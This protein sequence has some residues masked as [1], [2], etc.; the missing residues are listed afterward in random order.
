MWSYGI[1]YDQILTTIKSRIYSV[2]PPYLGTTMASPI[3]FKRKLQSSFSKILGESSF[4]TKLVE[5]LYS[6]Y[7]K[8]LSCSHMDFDIAEVGGVPNEY[9]ERHD[10]AFLANPFSEE[11]LEAARRVEH[12]ENIFKHIEKAIIK[13]TILSLN[14]GCIGQ[15]L[16]N[17]LIFDGH[18][19]GLVGYQSQLEIKKHMQDLA[20]TD[21]VSTH[22]SLVLQSTSKQVLDIVEK[23]M[24]LT[25]ANSK[26]SQK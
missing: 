16:L 1:K 5:K 15:L 14:L 8:V 20:F 22:H 21:V 23:N 3:T 19:D 11:N 10:P 6:T 9:A 17:N 18:S 24:D 13:E 4:T 7:I 25:G 2:S 12:Y 26:N